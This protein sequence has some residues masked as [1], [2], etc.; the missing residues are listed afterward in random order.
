MRTAAT[1]E[2]PGKVTTLTGNV[3]YRSSAPHGGAFS[4]RPQSAHLRFE[5]VQG[6]TCV[7]NTC[8][9]GRDDGGK[10]ATPPDYAIVLRALADSVVANNVKHQRAL[11]KLIV[12]LG[13]HG[14]GCIEG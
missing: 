13:G 7:G 8:D 4:D 5:E 11:K 1:R 10:G 2:K 3:I 6:L 12:D 9:V 14:G